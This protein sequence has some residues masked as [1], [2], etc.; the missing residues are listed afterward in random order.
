MPRI[1]APCIFHCSL[2]RWEV[3]IGD[4]CWRT[5]GDEI[6]CMTCYLAQENN[7]RRIR[8]DPSDFYAPLPN[9]V[10]T[11]RGIYER[12]TIETTQRKSLDKRSTIDYIYLKYS[13]ELAN[14]EV[15]FGFNQG[16]G[17]AEFYEFVN[18]IAMPIY[19]IK[20]SK[21]CG[22][23]VIDILESD[24]M[25]ELRV[26]EEIKMLSGLFIGPVTRRIKI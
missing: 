17:H 18:L 13:Q 12:S 15:R 26:Q 21:R 7:N 23:L 4:L 22:I 6:L 14:A 16:G 1:T 10:I 11:E 2:C 9:D 3:R 24:E 8:S 5:E 20:E 19:K 25:I